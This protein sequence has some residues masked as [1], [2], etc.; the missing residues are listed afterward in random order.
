MYRWGVWKK[1]EFR[2]AGT[3]VRQDIHT[4]EIVVCQYFYFEAITY[5][6]VEKQRLH[7]EREMEPEDVR[8]VRRLLGALSWLADQT[9]PMV[10]AR[11]GILLVS[12]EDAPTR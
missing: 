4:K 8:E 11:V 6:D 2:F 7:S 12:M 5:L 3:N 9:G 1:S 10:S